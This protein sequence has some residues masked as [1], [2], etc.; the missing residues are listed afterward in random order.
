MPPKLPSFSGFLVVV[1]RRGFG[2]LP[3]VYFKTGS[4]KGTQIDVIFLRNLGRHCARIAVSQ[5]PILEPIVML[6]NVRIDWSITA[7]VVL[8]AGNLAPP[9]RLLALIVVVRDKGADSGNGCAR[10]GRECGT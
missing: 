5:Q 8:W 4:R 3:C 1:L 9:I 7:A 10:G 2:S 6:V